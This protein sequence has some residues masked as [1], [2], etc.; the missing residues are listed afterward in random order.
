MFTCFECKH[1]F[2]SIQS[3]ITHFKCFHIFKANQI[4]KCVQDNCTSQFLNINK[5]KRHLEQH[6][7]FNKIECSIDRNILTIPENISLTEESKDSNNYNPKYI[8]CNIKHDDFFS[9]EN[10]EEVQNVCLDFVLKLNSY[11]HMT[12]KQIDEIISD[13]SNLLQLIFEKLKPILRYIDST[14]KQKF[15][16]LFEY[17]A[18]PFK[19][20]GTEFK[21]HSFLHDLK[22]IEEPQ[23]FVI[24][25]TVKLV[26]K[27]GISNFS[28]SLISG[29]ILPI[30]F[31]FKS[32]FETSN[33]L[34]D[35]L[36]HIKKLES[37]DNSIISDFLQGE[38]WKKKRKQYPND[39]CINY[40]LY[41]DDFEAGNPLGSH[42]GSQAIAAFY[43]NIPSLSRE[44]SSR[45]EYIFPVMFVRTQD[46]K[47]FGS[48]KCI[49]I[50]VDQLVLLET[51]GI[52]FKTKDDQVLTIRFLLGLIIGDNLAVNLLLGFTQSFSHQFYCRI[53]L[54]PKVE[55]QTKNAE[56]R[57]LYRTISNYEDQ[58]I[59]KTY[60]ESG[61]KFE[62]VLN[63]I[64]SF[65]VTENFYSDLMHDTFEG[66][67]KYG[68]INSISY[69]IAQEFFTLEELND[70]LEF[71]DYGEIEVRNKC[72][73]IKPNHL[74]E[75]KLQAS[76][77]E[78]MSLL[79]FFSLMVG[80]KI[81]K[82][83]KIWKYILLLEKIMFKISSSSF[84]EAEI[85]E[86]EILISKHH[87]MYIEIFNDTLKPKHHL[88]TH[89]G[90]LIR[91][92]GPLKFLW[93]MRFE[94]KN[95]EMKSYTNAT[96]SRRN[97]PYSLAK[98]CSLKLAH[99]LNSCKI[100]HNDYSS[101]KK[102]KDK[103]NYF[104]EIIRNPISFDNYEH[105]QFYSEIQYQGTL[106]K[107]NF[108]V[109]KSD[110]FFKIT[111]IASFENNT[112]LLVKEAIIKSIDKH[113]Q[114][115]II[116]HIKTEYEIF[117]IDLFQMKPFLSYTLMDGRNVLKLSN[118]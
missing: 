23:Q 56:N 51:K 71:F 28:D 18:D 97:L 20:F 91:Y 34:E 102:K 117:S 42:S 21:L 48:N 43:I 7:N 115:F 103:I 69:F 39:L 81:P 64:P 16:D 118:F 50:L 63:E 1:V 82:S 49:Q 67:I 31:I 88:M 72:P 92:S 55:N 40:N 84:T 87:A 45:V 4:Y 10:K 38:L 113:F 114:C 53:C 25:K 44:L 80:H 111:D 110:M 9:A 95:K 100:K 27:K 96:K 93:C 12:A 26:N 59:N 36:L 99:F 83:N 22:L 89:Y 112:F 29:T 86:T 98:K 101:F 66:V 106:Y 32:L 46:F 65:H 73:K 13:T 19:K 54:S 41:Y 61:I 37:C 52:D 24:D 109:Y 94:S 35:A 104:H 105:L 62:S 70:K 90:S 30:S 15:S 75:K 33:N 17:C 77:R 6:S 2:E 108:F 57:L 11:S 76:A 85:C 116:S 74:K 79:H 68:L 5:L 107:T 78:T 14:V 58:L 60:A 3:L 47:K 8:D